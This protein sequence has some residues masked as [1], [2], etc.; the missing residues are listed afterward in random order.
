VRVVRAAKTPVDPANGD[1]IVDGEAVGMHAARQHRVVR[2]RT[3]GSL[4]TADF[5]SDLESA[6]LYA[7]KQARRFGTRA[8]AKD[9]AKYWTLSLQH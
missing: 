8:L 2:V 6:R 3:V 7:C 1:F 9:G 4:A 5:G